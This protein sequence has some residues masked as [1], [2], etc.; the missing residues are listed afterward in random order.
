[1]YLVPV[2]VL[3]ILVCYYILRQLHYIRKFKNLGIT[4]GGNSRTLSSLGLKNSLP[5]KKMVSAQIFI[6]VKD[7][8]FYLEIEK[9]ND[10][11]KKRRG[12]FY[13]ITF[14]FIVIFLFILNNFYP[15]AS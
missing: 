1:M 12:L 3:Y 13:S 9:G 15:P 7:N 10:F 8:K 11:A 4:H 14:F 5:F 6:P 2:V